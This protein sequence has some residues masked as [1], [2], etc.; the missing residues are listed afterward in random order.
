MLTKD[1]LY[2]LPT[3]VGVRYSSDYTRYALFLGIENKGT[4][5]EAAVITSEFGARA[6]PLMKNYG[7]TWQIEA[8]INGG[9]HNSG[10][11]L[12]SIKAFAANNFTADDENKLTIPANGCACSTPW[13][14]RSGRF[15]LDDAA[16]VKEWGLE[17]VLRFCKAAESA[18]PR[19]A[20]AN[21]DGF[22]C[23]RRQRDPDTNPGNKPCPDTDK[24][25]L[26]GN[27]ASRSN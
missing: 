2:A 12:A 23:V 17:T 25:H 5:K 4:D 24:C 26:C 10:A 22:Y 8:V 20:A 21:S 27:C 13:M 15:E 9:M 6:R 19:K 16:A 11:S 14:D 1:E 18:M 3:G 7:K